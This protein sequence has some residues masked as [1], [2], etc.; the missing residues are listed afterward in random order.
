MSFRIEGIDHVH[1]TAPEGSEDEARRFYG[2][3]LGMIEVP[4]PEV[5]QHNGGCWFQFGNQQVH[6]GMLEPFQAP[7]KVH[8]AFM[9]KNLHAL[10][11]RLEE[12]PYPVQEEAPIPGRTRFFVRDPFGNKIEF[13]EYDA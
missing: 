2:D 1:I 12:L 9:V 7:R 5:F 6:I 11:T 3:L 13:L 8:T 4:K 10:R